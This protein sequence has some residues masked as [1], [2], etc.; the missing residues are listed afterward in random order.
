MTNAEVLGFRV[1]AEYQFIINA[2]ILGS[3]VRAEHQFVTLQ[4]F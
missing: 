3:R 1:R 4:K 2:E